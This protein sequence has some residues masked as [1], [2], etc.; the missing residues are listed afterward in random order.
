MPSLFI[1]LGFA[2]IWDLQIYFFIKLRKMLC[3]YFFK[4]LIWGLLL[5]CKTSDI[6]LKITETYLFFPESSSLYIFQ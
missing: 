6:L 2:G 1:L 3:Y 4:Y 5:I